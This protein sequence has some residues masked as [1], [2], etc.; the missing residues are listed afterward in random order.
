MLLMFSVQNFTPELC[1]KYIKFYVFFC[2]KK[3][4]K[5]SALS[6]HHDSVSDL[7]SFHMPLHPI[8]TYIY[9]H[10]HTLKKIL[11]GN[12]YTNVPF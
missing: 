3:Y 1:I 2:K 7:P 9:M 6:R 8:P 11:S 12:I 10:T 4:F 5:V